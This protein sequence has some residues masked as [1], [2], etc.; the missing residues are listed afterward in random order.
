M[1]G[2]AFRILVEGEYPLEASVQRVLQ[3]LV[4]RNRDAQ[5]SPI[6]DEMNLRHIVKSSVETRLG[7]FVRRVVDDYH[8]RYLGQQFSNPNIEFLVGKIGYHYR[9]H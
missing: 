6:V 7:G 5:I 8:P 4:Q 1:S 3:A 9:A 2:I